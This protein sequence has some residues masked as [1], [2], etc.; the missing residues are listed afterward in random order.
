MFHYGMIN[1]KVN[2]GHHDEE[3]NVEFLNENRSFKM[4]GQETIISVKKN[5]SEKGVAVHG[6][7]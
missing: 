4:F 7:E 3:G 6:Y 5:L 2:R 1:S